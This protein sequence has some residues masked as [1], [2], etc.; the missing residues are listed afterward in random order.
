RGIED[1]RCLPSRPVEIH[2]C[3]DLAVWTDFAEPG[4]VLLPLAGIDRDKL[5]FQF[6]FLEKK[7]DLGRIRGRMIIKT[8]HLQKLL[9]GSVRMSTGKDVSTPRSSGHAYGQ[10][11]RPAAT[12]TD[13]LMTMGSFY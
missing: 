3:R 7:R 6:S 5:I 12:R 8:N 13:K 2:N 11:N 1:R 10:R 4:I 9:V